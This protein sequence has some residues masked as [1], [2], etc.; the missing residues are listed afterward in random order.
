MLKNREKIKWG[1][2]AL[3]VL[4]GVSLSSFSYYRYKS[5]DHCSVGVWVSPNTDKSLEILSDKIA[6]LD[7]IATQNG[8]KDA[9]RWNVIDKNSILLEC[10][11]LDSPRKTVSRFQCGNT[12]KIG[13]LSTG[14]DSSEASLVM[15]RSD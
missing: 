15:Y 4:A 8:W 7:R 11:L 14:L 10:A 13:Y 3:G 1:I 2:L 12:N 5:L 6:I 9:C